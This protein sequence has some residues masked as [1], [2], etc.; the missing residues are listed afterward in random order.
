MRFSLQ[1]TSSFGIACVVKHRKQKSNERKNVSFNLFVF[2]RFPRPFFVFL[3]V[4]D[5]QRRHE[6]IKKSEALI[7]EL[8]ST[9]GENKN[10]TPVLTVKQEIWR[11]NK[12]NGIKSPESKW[13]KNKS[14]LNH[15]RNKTKCYIF[16]ASNMKSEFILQHRIQ[17]SR[18]Q[19]NFIFHAAEWRIKR[20]A[21]KR[22]EMFCSHS[23]YLHK[24]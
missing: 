23:F 15:E 3:N 12:L 17:S 5:L 16:V 1:N 4:L 22:S 11:Q 20:A 2:S 9:E 19:K 6:F 8:K 21:I 14:N 18:K 10:D 13:K 7:A 24:C